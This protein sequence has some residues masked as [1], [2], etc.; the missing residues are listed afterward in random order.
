MPEINLNSLKSLTVFKTLYENGTATKTAKALGITQSGVSRSL[1]ILEENLGIPLFI[2]EKNRLISTPEAEELYKEILGLMFILD[3]VKHSILALKEFGASRVRIA[4]IP[5]L[6]FGYVPKLISKVLK[7]N[8]KLNIY[9]DIMST[10]DVVRSVESGLFDVGF[11]TLPTSSDQLQVDT[12]IKTE[13]V[14]I[15][16]KKHPLA[17][18]QKI[19]LQDLSNQHLIIPNQPNIAADQLLRLI[20]EKRI[21]ITGKTEANIAGICSLVGNN[22]G[23]SVINPITS[24]DLGHKNMVTRPFSPTIN[25]SFGLIYRKNWRGNKLIQLIREILIQ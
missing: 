18:Q 16:N 17:K 12:I 11:I 8:P 5:G 6:A 13:A 3:E 23:V 24:E 9:F 10:N 2:R 1:G 14:C 20:T 19:D 25:Y 15:L 4:T 21:K 7:H 22:V